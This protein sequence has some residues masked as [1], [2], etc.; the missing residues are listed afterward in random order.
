MWLKGEPVTIVGRDRFLAVVY[1]E[2]NPLPDGTKK[3]GYTLFDAVSASAITSESVSSISAGSLLEWTGL[4][5]TS[6]SS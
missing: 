1:R 6:L 4:A 5:T 2:S 3:L